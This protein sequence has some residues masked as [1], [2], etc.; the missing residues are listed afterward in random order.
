MLSEDN[1]YIREELTKI[2]A[3]KTLKKLLQKVL[4]VD[5]IKRISAK[6]TLNEEYFS[7]K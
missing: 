6:E 1:D 7:D 4:E 5:P 2:K 3:S